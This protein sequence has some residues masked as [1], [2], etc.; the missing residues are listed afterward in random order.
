MFKKLFCSPSKVPISTRIILRNTIKRSRMFNQL[1]LT[2]NL[3]ISIVFLS[4]KSMSRKI[5]EWY[6]VSLTSNFSAKL[7]Q[8][9]HVGDVLKTLV[10][11]D[12]KSVPGF[13]N[14]PILVGVIK[15]N[16][17]CN[18]FCQ[19]C[20]Y[21]CMYE[22]LNIYNDILCMYTFILSISIQ[23][24]LFMYMFNQCN[25]KIPVGSDLSQ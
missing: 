11:A 2:Q 16:K 4:V 6:H 1:L 3:H 10:P 20:M 22:R 25:M 23:Y 9:V 19:Y 17:I 15:Q 13:K 7:G 12:F 14:W 21:L 8:I 5:K 24:L 18:S